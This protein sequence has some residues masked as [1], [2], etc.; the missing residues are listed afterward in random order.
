[1]LHDIELYRE[2]YEGSNRGDAQWQ[3][4]FAD[5]PAERQALEEI[6]KMTQA[7]A[8]D[9]FIETSCWKDDLPD[10]AGNKGTADERL[11]R[12]RFAYLLQHSRLRMY[13]DY[14]LLTPLEHKLFDLVRDMEKTCTDETLKKRAKF[15]TEEATRIADRA[16]R[17][18]WK[19][20][21]SWRNREDVPF[22]AVIDATD[23][24]T[25]EDFVDYYVA[26]D[27]PEIADAIRG[28][29]AAKKKKTA[30]KR[31]KK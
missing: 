25:L 12:L 17:R 22:A 14:A 16:K 21:E 10:L 7:A 4:I 5:D 29:M 30:G 15:A 8:V 27:S 3:L 18:W 19:E 23:A 26:K 6:L 2:Y 31:R 1:M 24:E 13:T 11:H 28:G 9:D 20:M